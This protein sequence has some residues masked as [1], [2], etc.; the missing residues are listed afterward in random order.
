MNIKTQSV[1]FTA[2]EKLLTYIDKKVGKLDKL[3]GRI[4]DAEVILQLENSGQIRDKI[5]EIRIKIPG[6]VLFTKQTAKTFETA[7]DK[8]VNTLRRQLVRY[9]E[10]RSN[11]RKRRGAVS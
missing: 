10:R 8:S 1:H 4:L 5:A 11:V 6:T 7:V 3:H 2:D 9:K